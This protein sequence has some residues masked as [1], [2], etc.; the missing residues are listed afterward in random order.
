MA[1]E[2]DLT[3]SENDMSLNIGNRI[4]VPFADLCNKLIEGQ[5]ADSERREF[6]DVLCDAIAETI[7]LAI[8]EGVRSGPISDTTG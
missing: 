5:R 8:R 4:R 2:D 7:A 1:G 3:I 6:Q